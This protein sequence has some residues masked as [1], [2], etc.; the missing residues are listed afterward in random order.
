MQKITLD[1]ETFVMF[2]KQCCEVYG[3]SINDV[4]TDLTFLDPP[5]P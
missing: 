1:S 2:R 5:H 4:T 3:L